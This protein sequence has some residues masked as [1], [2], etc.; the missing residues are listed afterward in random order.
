ME[1][2][3]PARASGALDRLRLKPL[4][5]CSDVA[6]AAATLRVPYVAGALSGLDTGGDRGDHGTLRRGSQFS[7]DTLGGVPEAVAH[8]DIVVRWMLLPDA[9]SE[10]VFGET[11]LTIGAVIDYRA[12][13][14]PAEAVLNCADLSKRNRQQRLERQG[15]DS[16]ARSLAGRT[17]YAWT[18]DRKLTGGRACFW[19]T[20]TLL[21]HGHRAKDV[22]AGRQGTQRPRPL[23]G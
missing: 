17:R 15:I 8:E 11:L 1:G 20:L 16:F 10:I 2:G 9:L 21:S 6:E 12:V 3:R 13:R 5:H 19:G 22:A 14:R 18:G 7:L 23:G 4:R